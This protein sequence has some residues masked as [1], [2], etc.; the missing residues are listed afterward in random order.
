MIGP[1]LLLM[2]GASDALR[3]GRPQRFGWAA[4]IA[5]SLGLGV[6]AVYGMGMPIAWASGCLGITVCWLFVMPAHG[7]I[8]P[9]R[10]WPAFM[11]L[12]IVALVTVIDRS[13][14]LLHGPI[15]DMYASAVHPSIAGIPSPLVV[16]GIAAALFL[17]RSSN[18]IVRA[19]LGHAVE[20]DI[21]SDDERAVA[22]WLHREPPRATLRGGRVIGPLERI[23]L[24]FLA[25]TGAYPVIAALIA[26]KGIVRFPEIS[27]DRGS[28]SKAEEFLVGSFTSWFI[29]ALAAGYL[30]ALHF[31]SA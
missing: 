19:A 26:A 28:G 16:G 14:D 15:V 22:R 10:L 17:T 25:L 6:A 29:A 30:F 2:I 1:L 31:I 11:L 27:T 21:D 18:L 20:D 8:R 12:L 9:H 23:L 13:G 5:T 3:S 7:E 4:S 24:V